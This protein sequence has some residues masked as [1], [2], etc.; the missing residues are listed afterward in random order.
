MI[1][2]TRYQ[3]IL[4]RIAAS[5]IDGIIFFPIGFVAGYFID[6]TDKLIYQASSITQTLLFA[7]YMIIGHAKYGYTIGKKIFG[8]QVMNL[9][10]S[11]N[12]S[13]T[14]AFLRDS[15]WICI[16]LGLAA[17]ALVDPEMLS[18]GINAFSYQDLSLWVLYGWYLFE[19]IVVL[20]NNKRRAIHDFMAGSVVIIRS[21]FKRELLAPEP[22]DLLEQVPA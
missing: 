11:S 6:Q 19:F 2:Q 15:V 14:M 16:E 18:I 22:G 13:Y 12:L 3:T 9:A 10:E 1:I 8:L 17:Y 7:A 20:L 5:F 4:R 21:E